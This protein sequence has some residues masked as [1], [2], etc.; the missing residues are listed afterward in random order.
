M[1]GVGI[2]DRVACLI[3]FHDYEAGP[4]SPRIPC[5][6]VERC[7]RCGHRHPSGSHTVHSWA[8]PLGAGSCG[9]WLRCTRCGA[10]EYASR[11]MYARIGERHVAGLPSRWGNEVPEELR[12][13]HPHG[14]RI[15]LGPCDLVVTCGG[16][17]YVTA[18]DY[19]FHHGTGTYCTV[20]GERNPP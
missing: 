14:E 1:G 13:P 16:C 4:V 12:R 2:R 19:G 5:R 18:V 6:E 15:R 7:R 8:T 3:G 10:E 11:H 9:G 20:C 17:G